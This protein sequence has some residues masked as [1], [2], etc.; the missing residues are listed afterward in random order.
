MT[1]WGL[2]EMPAT[3]KVYSFSVMILNL[4]QETG[5]VKVLPSRGSVSHL[6]DYESEPSRLSG[7]HHLFKFAS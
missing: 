7:S 1:S 5:Y 2:K 4:S 6:R 3:E